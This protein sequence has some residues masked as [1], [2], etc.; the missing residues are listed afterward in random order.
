MNLAGSL[1]QCAAPPRAPSIETSSDSPKCAGSDA[2]RTRTI[3]SVYD[4]PL[5]SV[6]VPVYNQAE[7]ILANVDEIEQ[8]VRSGLRGATYE[9]IVVSDG[10]AD[11]TEQVLRRQPRTVGAGLSLRPQLGKGYALKLGASRRA[12]SRIG[13][14]DSDLD[15]DP[16]ALPRFLRHAETRELDIVIG[17][18][19]HPRVGRS[20][21]AWRAASGAGCISA[22]SA[23]LFRL[24]V[25]DTQ[26]GLKV[27]RREVADEVLPLLMVKRFAFDLELLAVARAL[28]FSRIEEQPIRLDYRFTGSGVRSIAV[29]R[30][31]VDTAAIFYRLRI[32][33]YYQRKR[34]SRVPSAGRGHAAY[35]AA[36]LRRH[37]RPGAVPRARLAGA[38][39]ARRTDGRARRRSS[40]RDRARTVTCSRSSSLAGGRRT[41]GCRGDRPFL[42]RGEIAAV[43][44]PKMA[45]HDGPLGYRAAAAIAESR[46]GGGS[47]YFR[48]HA[49]QPPVRRRL[50]RRERRCRKGAV[51]R[52]RR[53]LW[54]WSTCPCA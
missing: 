27:F 54:T 30:A 48:Y 32:L 11:D 10:S 21:S 2:A 12:G 49:G 47:L 15:L 9:L 29:L 33:R 4:E 45:P 35:R 24:D 52:A 17:S 8:R 20:L 26:V 7:S 28:G 53:S 18:K 1:L 42:G 44:V 34:R 37:G 40:C 41:T 31:L 3:V 50:P 46:L 25:R 6:V 36:R 5:L 38:R 14:C 16:G 13:F 19:R 43:V 22:W 51:S 23:S 39:G